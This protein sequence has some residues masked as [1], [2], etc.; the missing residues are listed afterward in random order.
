MKQMF[1]I[2]Q[3]LFLVYKGIANPTLEPLDDLPSQAPEK[4]NTSI[5]KEFLWGIAGFT[6]TFLPGIIGIGVGGQHGEI[7]EAI[8]FGLI[9]LGIG[10]GV[11]LTTSLLFSPGQLFENV[12]PTYTGVLV[13][14]GT[15]V[16][17]TVAIYPE[18]IAALI[19]LPV[20]FA[21]RAMGCISFQ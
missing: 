6:L 16:V 20:L 9:G 3:M 7:A 8:K 15:L 17:V 18:L 21:L 1:V 2:V 5:S 19:I 4:P 11:S 12:K 13:G 14:F 10:A